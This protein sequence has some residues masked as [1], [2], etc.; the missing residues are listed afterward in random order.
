LESLPADIQDALKEAARRLFEAQ[1]AQEQYDTQT[2][3]DALH[4]EA[5]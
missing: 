1:A 3:L 2:V 4:T 5:A